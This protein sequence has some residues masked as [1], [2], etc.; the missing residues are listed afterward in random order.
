[1]R[2]RKSRMVKNKQASQSHTIS[3]LIDVVLD[4]K[5]CAPRKQHRLIRTICNG[6]TARSKNHD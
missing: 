2:I 3:E 1:M 4:V 6:A 5:P